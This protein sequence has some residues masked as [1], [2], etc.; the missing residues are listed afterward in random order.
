MIKTITSERHVA[1]L[2]AATR[3]RSTVIGAALHGASFRVP[4]AQTRPHHPHRGVRLQPVTLAENVIAS[5][6]TDHASIKV[7]VTY[8][9]PTIDST[10]LGAL[11][12]TT[13]LAVGDTNFEGSDAGRTTNIEVGI[14]LLN[15]TLVAP[16]Q[17]GGSGRRN[18][19]PLRPGPR[20][21]S[22]TGWAS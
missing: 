17:R 9:N 12:I 4:V 20:G 8:K 16:G 15:G 3:H 14:S 11:G 5:F 2:D 1:L 7:P 10:N 6:T 19:P 13:K 18:A 21:S 22:P